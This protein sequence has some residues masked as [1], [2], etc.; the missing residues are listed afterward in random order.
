M[1]LD[2]RLCSSAFECKQIVS[3]KNGLSVS[4]L[5]FVAIVSERSRGR[6]RERKRVRGGVVC[7]CLKER[8]KSYRDNVVGRGLQI[9]KEE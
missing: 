7:V 9:K 8:E 4:E 1:F 6:E 5:K 3:T 2:M